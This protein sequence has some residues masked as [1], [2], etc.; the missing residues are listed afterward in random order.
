[1]ATIK[2]KKVKDLLKGLDKRILIGFSLAFPMLIFMVVLYF[3][4][5]YKSQTIQGVVE[6]TLQKF[7]PVLT[8]SSQSKFNVYYPNI[9]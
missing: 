7:V 8:S 2:L 4:S 6:S 9:S 1:M 3:V 5:N